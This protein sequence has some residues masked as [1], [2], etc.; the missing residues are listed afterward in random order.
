MGQTALYLPSNEAI[1]GIF[2]PMMTRP[3]RKESS[4]NTKNN[5]RY[6]EMAARME[7][8]MLHF[9]E[10]TDLEKITVKKICEAAQVNRSTFYAHYLD[11]YDM[12]DQMETHLHE[13]M[14]SHY[15]ETSPPVF[16]PD[17]S[18]IPFLT[19]IREHRYFYRIA[20]RTR[21]QFPLKQ[22]YDHMWNLVIKP[23]CEKAGITSESEMMYYFIYFQAGFTYALR[24]WV[25]GG[26]V[27]SEETIAGI[28][29]SCLPAIWGK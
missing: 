6:Q 3:L 11:I 28:L 13:E 7:Q 23:R 22:G 20:L 12:V 17:A 16:M 5:Q 8:A 27:E 26:C 19:H 10:T 1:C 21:R 9:M 15:E 4:M 25:D 14:L 2:I 18:M 24:H 29:E